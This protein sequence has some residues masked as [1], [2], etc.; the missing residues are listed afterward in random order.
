[1]KVVKFFARAPEA[2]SAAFLVGAVLILL[3]LAGSRLVGAPISG[4]MTLAMALM[5]WSI[6]LGVSA[7]YRSGALVTIDTIFARIPA[8]AR[9]I[10]EIGIYLLVAVFLITLIVL[11][12]RLLIHHSGRTLPGLPI[13]YS[14]MIAAMPVSSI[15]MLVTTV[16]SLYRLIRFSDSSIPNDAEGN[17]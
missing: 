13:P 1:M 16:G 14:A 11:S 17:G 4:L 12:V 10:V 3:L 2:L 7:A 15:L 9:R 5:T 6:F 8:A